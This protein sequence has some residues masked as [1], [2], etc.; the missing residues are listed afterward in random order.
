M[1]G[2]VTIDG[3][4]VPID[5]Q[6][7][8]LEM[9]RQAGIDLPTFCYHSELS[10]YGAC[11]MCVVED[12]RGAVLSSCSTPPADG[13]AIRTNTPRLLHIRKMMLELLLANHDRDCTTCPR[14][15]KCKLQELAARFGIDRVR[16]PSAK[17][18]APLDLSSPSLV[19]DPNKCILCGDCVR[20]CA[21]VQDVGAIDLAYRGAKALVTPAYNRGL[22]EV[23]CVHCGQCATVCP[24]GALTVRPEVQQVYRALRDPQK[25]VVV[26]VAPAVRVAIGEEFGLRPGEISTGQMVAAIR[27]LGFARVFDTSFSADLTTIEETNEFIGRV[28]QGHRLPLFTSCCPAWVKLVEQS[29]P[30]KLEHLSSCRSPQ[31]MFGSVIKRHYAARQNIA[32]QDI[33]AVSVM[34]CTAK[35]FEAQRPEFA[36]GEGA[37]RVRDVDAVLTTQELAHMIKAA[38]IVFTELAEESFD[39][40]FGFATGAG[41]LFGASGG[42]A[43]AVVREATYQLT[44]QRVIDVPLSPVPSLPGVSAAQLTLGEHTVRLAVVSGLGNARRLVEA[45]DRGEVAYDIVE[46]MACPGGCAGGAGQPTPNQTP[47][48]LARARGLRAADVRQQVRLAQ[49]NPLVLGLY[50][51]WLERPNSDEAHHALHTR[52]VS[53]RR[54]APAVEPLDQQER[55]AAQIQVC[56]GTSCYLRGA[57]DILR[58][59]SEEIEA[60]GLESA[61]DLR[62]AFCLEQCDRGPNVRI[63]GCERCGVTPEQAPELL[64]QALGETL[65][66]S[67]PA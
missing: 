52:Y 35:K 44:Q 64:R 26:Q 20:M 25:H 28:L 67:A 43:T 65:A 31:Q 27:R 12:G 7:N 9:V 32:P 11:R 14:N 40:P 45:M 50:H 2:T 30:D 54:V 36:L 38:G 18:V 23:N 29:Y 4:A 41:V 53:R 5:G 47:Q 62:A 57:R 33:Y 63:N 48:R 58:R 51:Q 17:K 15:G 46:V 56:V 8:L 19:R 49:D 59:L 34:P 6:R 16:F 21:E 37:E 13:M 61:V 1:A 10:V 22:G 39:S 66:E 60:R 3:I 42:V 24:T 55:P